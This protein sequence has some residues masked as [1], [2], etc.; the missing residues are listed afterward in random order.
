MKEETISI[1][2]INPNT[3]FWYFRAGERA[4]FYLDF[5]YNNYIS[6]GSPKVSLDLIH[7]TVL[8][9]TTSNNHL[10]EKSIQSIYENLF[11]EVHEKL[12]KESETYQ[13]V[14]KRN[15]PPEEKSTEKNRLLKIAKNDA[16]ARARNAFIFEQ[17]M[18]VGDVVIVPTYGSKNLL[19]GIVF[20]G[21]NSEETPYFEVWEDDKRKDY[22][23]SDYTLKRQVYWIR[24]IDYREFPKELQGIRFQHRAIN[25]L[26]E[27]LDRMQLILANRF[28]YENKVHSRIDVQTQKPVFSNSLF[29]LQKVIKELNVDNINIQQKTQIASP[30]WI[31]F[32]TNLSNWPGMLTVSAVLTGAAVQLIR[33][34]KLKLE[35]IACLIPHTKTREIFKENREAELNEA[36]IR[37]LKSE[38]EL[39]NFNSETQESAKKI[40]G[41]SDE[42]LKEAMEVRNILE[43][44]ERKIMKLPSSNQ[45]KNLEK[46]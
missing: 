25:E 16:R 37:R 22:P 30:G 35:D 5:K 27:N 24:E 43:I 38:Q 10:T 32:I 40:N 44:D 46:K 20:S 17:K 8:E 13:K 15:I 3:K 18:S 19:I 11:S 2:R 41:I 39:K 12:M 7:T 29:D 34:S 45:E 23:K 36:K 6:T 1:L 28:V 31:E 26:T 4:S 21:V 33:N 42:T 9:K 14:D